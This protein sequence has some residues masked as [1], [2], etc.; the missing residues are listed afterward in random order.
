[1]VSGRKSKIYDLSIESLLA[2]LIVFS[3]LAYGAVMPWAV[4]VFEI[5]A[6]LMAMLWIFRMLA[7]E[8]FEFMHNPLT[9]FILLFLFYAGLQ[10]FFSIYPHATRDELLKLISYAL[11]FFVSINTIK[12]K[13]QINRLLSCVVIVGFLTSIFYLMRHFGMKAPA[14][15][16]NKDHF[17]GYLA[18]V[19][20]IAFGF[21][22]TLNTLHDHEDKTRLRGI[23]KPYILIFY[24]ILVMA[25]ALFITASRG[26][27]FSFVVALLVMAVLTITK[28]TIAKKGWIFLAVLMFV[29][30]VVAW[31]G[32]TPV[33]ERV[34]RLKTEIAPR[35]LC[36]RFPL[37][38]GAISIIKES[39]V[40][41][42][43]MGTFGYVFPKFQTA[44][45]ISNNRTYAHA[46]CDFLE[47]LSEAGM[48]GFVIFISGFISFVCYAFSQFRK[49][50]SPY[51]VGMSMGLLGSLASVFAHSFIDFSLRIPAIAI[52][53]VL[54]V[55]ALICVFN[56]PSSVRTELA[57]KKKIFNVRNRIFSLFIYASTAV[58]TG[59]FL[60]ACVRPAIAD[61]YFSTKRNIEL[62]IKFDPADAGYYYQLGKSYSKSSALGFQISAYKK[63][64]LL[65][66]TN[67]KYHQ[68]LAWA[69]GQ[70]ADQYTHKKQFQHARYNS[71]LSSIEF[72]KAIEFEPNNAY[73]HRAYA[74]WLFDHP[75]KE[76]IRQG[77]SEYK[78]AVELNQDLAEELNAYLTKYK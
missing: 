63:A 74:I 9:I 17:S 53:F 14:G 78:K 61:H 43:G 32:A 60:I 28:K 13:Q 57:D 50:Y 64:V 44:E 73:R 58:L 18:M 67:S 72:S 30:M 1:M 2:L 52:L 42:T 49:R 76:N 26:G 62:A 40:F 21:L 23:S 25:A 29:L 7:E 47:L 66:P 5:T 20:P 33:L 54:I 12:T 45:I 22:F 70:L 65:N 46:H 24:S 41:G 71:R 39:P 31:L 51:V 59:L 16:I 27:M 10:L 68:S 3:P 69:Y 19:I 34:L 8:R 56:I 6:A 15:I 36:G 75:D 11:I 37:W 38:A 48:A 35:Y 55:S 77:I 4:A